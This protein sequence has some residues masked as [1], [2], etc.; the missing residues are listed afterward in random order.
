MLYRVRVVGACQISQPIF[1]CSSRWRILTMTRW[2]VAVQTPPVIASNPCW[3]LTT[4]LPSTGGTPIHSPFLFK[5]SS[6]PVLSCERNVNSP[7]ES[8]CGPTPCEPGADLGYL[9]NLSRLICPLKLSNVSGGSERHS[10]TRCTKSCARLS[11]CPMY[12]STRCWTPGCAGYWSQTSTTTNL[13]KVTSA[14]LIR[15]FEPLPERILLGPRF[16]PGSTK[17]ELLDTSALHAS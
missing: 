14:Y 1:N 10:A 9:T 8:L 4:K 17:I 5:T 7:A 11:I 13:G 3:M 12:S 15:A 6:P 2:V 16:D